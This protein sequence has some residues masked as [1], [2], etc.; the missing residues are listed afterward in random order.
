M[1]RITLLILILLSILALFTV[2]GLTTPFEESIVSDAQEFVEASTNLFDNGP[3][4]FEKSQSRMENPQTQSSCHYQNIFD[5]RTCI[6]NCFKYSRD[7]VTL[8]NCIKRCIA[9]CSCYIS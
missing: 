8:K 5:I 7:C 6:S 4:C 9:N 2:T 3:I 1:G